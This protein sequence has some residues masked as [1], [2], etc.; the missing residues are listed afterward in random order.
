MIKSQHIDRYRHWRAICI[1]F[2]SSKNYLH[3]PNKLLS[4]TNLLY[5]REIYN[6]KN[7][8]LLDNCV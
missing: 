4:E 5:S 6:L 8:V 2:V 1:H 3:C 7:S